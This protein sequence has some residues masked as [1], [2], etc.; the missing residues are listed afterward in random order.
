[1]DA[2]GHLGGQRPEVEFRAEAGARGELVHHGH[3]RAV[4]HESGGHVVGLHEDAL[5]A[6]GVVLHDLAGEQ[7]AHRAAAG[8]ADQVA[9]AGR[10]QAE[11]RLLAA[12]D[13]QAV[14]PS[15]AAATR[16]GR[17]SFPGP[18]PVVPKV[19]LNVQP[20]LLV[21]ERLQTAMR[22]LL[23][24]QTQMVSPSAETAIRPG[25]SK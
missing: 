18:L 12:S 25:K 4:P 19:V 6:A 24:S 3:A 7:G 1:M 21:L 15:G 20:A 5:A 13:T 2:E 14:R 8:Q 9:A 16:S 10:V 23:P 17:S 22:S 11:A